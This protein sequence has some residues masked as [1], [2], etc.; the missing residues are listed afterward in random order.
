MNKKAL[1]T[2]EFD[3]IV[4]KLSE[5]AYSDGSKKMCRDLK[6]MSEQEEIS[7]ALTE[8]SD[9]L[10]HI[11][12]QKDL[13]FKNIFDVRECLKRLELG[14]A[15]SI[16]ELLGIGG[17]LSSS[18]IAKSYFRERTDD[19]DV[20]QNSLDKYYQAI[21]P[22]SDLSREIA[23]CIVAE[24]EIA[25]DAS[26]ELLSVRRKLRQTSAKIHEVLTNILNTQ[27]NMLQE[28]L[29]T[30]RNGRYCL[31]VKAEHRSSFKGMVH[32]QSQT[33]ATL[34]IEPNS[35][36]KLNNEI[37]ELEG[38]EKKAIDKVLADLSN[39]CFES[40]REILSDYNVL[41]KLDF[42]FAKARFSRDYRGSKPEI[43]ADNSIELKKARHP[44]LDKNNCVPVDI[45]LGDGF[46]MLVITGPNTG[47]KTV[48][49]KT[50]GLLSLMG[51]AGLHIPAF[52]NSKLRLFKEIYADIGDEQ[53]IEQ[54]LSTF[55][56]HMVNTV[57]ILE[58]ADQNSLVLF[59][60]LG[61]GT[62]PVEG[63]ALATAILSFLHSKGI[64][65]CATTHYS[66]LK[67][68]A[69]TTEG[70]ENASCEF[71]VDTLSPTYKLLIG[72]PGKSN[73]FA[74]SK[75]LGISDEIIQ[76]AKENIEQEEKNFEDVI[77]ELQESRLT[78]DKE[79]RELA[80]KRREVSKLQ[81]ELKK[82]KE[83]INSSKQKILHNANKEASEILSNA[84][85]LADE[86]IRD[87]TRFKES[88]PDIREME[89]KRQRL[90]SEI[91][92]K[93][94]VPEEAPIL[95]NPLKKAK[96]SDLQIGTEIRVLS[97]NAAGTVS[98]LPDKKGNFS[99]H[100]GIIETKVNIDDVELL[101]AKNAGKKKTSGA[102][103]NA[104]DKRLSA[105]GFGS[106]GRRS[107]GYTGAGKIRMEKAR[108]IHGEVN[109]IGMTTDEAMPEMEKYLDDAY[110]S[111][112]NTVRVIHG[113]G[114]GAL[115]K[116]VQNRLK[117]LKYV[118]SY[119]NGEF[120]EGDVGVTIV[121]F[122]K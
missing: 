91:K 107:S 32:D 82:E 115:R 90:G 42:I 114:T 58:K 113:R 110:L 11:I 105:G 40:S 70:V 8:T 13:A 106:A 24:D 62:D 89:E 16:H 23:R 30:M 103:G 79:R 63:A 64:F 14:A 45:R 75:K 88:N 4:E 29:I 104:M 26:P 34:F 20:L 65:A 117:Q 77:G 99:V 50:I 112:L 95:R 1:K 2:L 44:L 55:S 96:P 101:H 53:S 7:L 49:L 18:S 36:V 31:P 15:L 56:A 37:R 39:Q 85:K 122:K 71:D 74:I 68:Y 69:L 118:E 54:S 111:G 5:F 86:T 12:T 84:K 10:T 93:G 100:I 6:P 119:R 19:K 80:D 120:G 121:T 27:S 67:T 3:K 25:D 48:S 108:E 109:L 41:T 66:E 57:G 47:G 60:E 116:A 92:K 94:S 52:D 9:A 46:D 38:D 28:N 21:F 35:V 78:L 43:S 102:Y 87:F 33:G 61:A 17:L 22:V 97:M 76:L 59:D 81:Q 73:A 51:Q 83:K 72:V 98:S